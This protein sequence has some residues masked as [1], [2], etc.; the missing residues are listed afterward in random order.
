MPKRAQPQRVYSG[1]EPVATADA[2]N[3]SQV[4]NDLWQAAHHQPGIPPPRYPFPLPFSSPVNAHLWVCTR[5]R[6]RGE[7]GGGESERRRDREQA[8]AF[9]ETGLLAKGHLPED[10]C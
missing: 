5:E 10:L 9:L 3:R 2:V 1:Q 8:S 4:S 7:G 6:E